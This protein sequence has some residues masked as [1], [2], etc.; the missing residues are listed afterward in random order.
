MR[1][2]NTDH[3]KLSRRRLIAA[4]GAIGLAGLAS[5]SS[6]ASAQD[7]SCPED[8]LDKIKKSGVFNLG[9][10]EA[11]PPYGYKDASG[12]YV[13]LAT[14]IAMIIYDAINKEL[15]GNIK[16]NYVPVTSQTRIPILQSGT[17]DAEAGATVVTRAR[18]KV[19]DF[20]LPHFVTATSILVPDASPI[21]SAA[22][23]AGKRIGIPQGGLEDALYKAANA[24]KTF[25]SPV[26]PRAFPDHAQGITALQTGSIDGYSS[27]EPILYDLAHKV[28]GFRVVPLNMNAFVQALLIRQGSPKFKRIL[29]LTIAEICASGRWQQLYD[30][31]FGKNGANI[32][33]S[34]AAKTLVQLNSWP[35]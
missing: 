3:D 24:A 31:Y 18:V 17:I 25:S 26:N 19:V 14:D 33:L 28:K 16:I 27:D 30:T 10:R 4:S 1:N 6:P 23:L 5:V 8:T 22:D 35:D 13:G 2:S 29:D 20:S 9:V 12:K 34:D 15:G 21:K 32:P 11:A 7:A